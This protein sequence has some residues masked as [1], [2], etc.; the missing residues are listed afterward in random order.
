MPALNPR[1][2][3]PS[4]SRLLAPFW[5]LPLLLV[6]TVRGMEPGEFWTAFNATEFKKNGWETRTHAELRFP[7]LDYLSYTRLSQK[8][9]YKAT[10]DFTLG[11]H[12]VWE[13]SRSNAHAEWKDT[14]RLDLE[15]NYAFKFGDFSIKTRNRYEVRRKEG[16]G[17]EAFDRFRQYTTVSYPV[18]WF[19]GMT[20][21]GLGNEVF[22]EFDETRITI[23]R[24]YPLQV[25]FKVNDVKLSVYAMYQIKRVGLSDDWRENWIVGTSTSFSF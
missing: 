15:A 25:G 6:A 19:E 14:W 5:L 3:M 7:E 22:V 2:T 21:L 16:K 18:H 1:S 9:F 23:N 24:F 20:S 12:P 11:V 10:A 8:F 17:S 4:R 13:R